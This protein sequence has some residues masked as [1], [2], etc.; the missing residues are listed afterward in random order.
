VADS[1]SD[2]VGRSDADA[3]GDA[4][5]KVAVG[6]TDSEKVADLDRVSVRENVG[7]GVFVTDFDLLK[8]RDTETD[9]PGDGVYVGEGVGVFVG[10]G[11]MDAV[12]VGGGDWVTVI[13]GTGLLVG[14][15][16]ALEWVTEAVFLVTV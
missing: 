12:T 13:V 14:D 15:T 1:E 7:P 5:E 10:G 2:A 11:V 4:A 16:V 8:V 9:G 3:D 6:S